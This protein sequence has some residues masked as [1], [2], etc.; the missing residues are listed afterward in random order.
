M[1]EPIWLSPE[2][3]IAIHDEQLAEFGGAPG[4][5]DAGALESALA[6]PLNRYH[7]GNTDLASLAAAYGFGLSRNHAFVDG[8]KRTAFLA[9]V[10]FLGL[11]E[12]DFVV[13]EPEAVVMMLALAAGEVDEAGLTQWIADKLRAA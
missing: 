5:R 8:N 11:N 10:T 4:L 6:R 9:I 7:Y 3:V 13:A 2:L 1:T 12:V